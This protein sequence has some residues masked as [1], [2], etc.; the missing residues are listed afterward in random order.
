MGKRQTT[1]GTR[2][3]IRDEK[4][5]SK[6]L[7]RIFKEKRMKFL[8]KIDHKTCG[9]NKISRKKSKVSLL[10]SILSAQFKTLAIIFSY[11]F[12]RW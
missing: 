2:H 8:F 6:I 12:C 1:S 3:V 9:Y 10:V 5:F 11:I 7:R 4:E